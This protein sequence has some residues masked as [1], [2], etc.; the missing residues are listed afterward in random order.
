VS[1]LPAASIVLCTRDRAEFAEATVRALLAGDEKPADVVVIDQSA[2]PSE[3]LPRLGDLVQYVWS[4]EPGLSRA[5][6]LG[7]QSAQHDVIVFVDD[8]VILPS[9]WLR[10]LLEPL[11]AG[12]ERTVVTGPVL[13][14]EG[15]PGMFAP[16]TVEVGPPA[17]H[18]GRIDADVFAGGNS[19]LRRSALEEVGGFDERLGAG[20]RYPAADDN[21][22][23]Y[24][25]LEAGYRIV[26]AP[27]AF[28][29]HRSWRPTR[30]FVRLRW[31]YGRGK[32]GFYAKHLSLRDRYMLRRAV[33]DVGA[34]IGRLPSG[35]RN[36]R[37]T[38][39]DLSYI[40]GVLAGAVEWL[41]IER[42]RLPRS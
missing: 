22:M 39:G 33:R 4:K 17:V 41:V 27:D 7:T 5:R 40:A 35:V 12:P 29:Y 18:M 11:V 24:R 3:T 32:G 31:R 10:S 25:L 2:E 13:A 21:D 42:G 36:R 19:A 26:F 23:G 20:A 38:A 16:S 8:D 34:R 37:R 15:R 14:E 6:N 1:A 28:L 9:H 30:A